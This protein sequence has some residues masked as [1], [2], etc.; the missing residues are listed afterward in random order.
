MLG[1]LSISPRKATL[2]LALGQCCGQGD[3]DPGL[4]AIFGG[5]IIDSNESSNNSINTKDAPLALGRASVRR[6]KH[7]GT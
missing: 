7:P 5:I 1:A 4:K 3:Q 6:L 2:A